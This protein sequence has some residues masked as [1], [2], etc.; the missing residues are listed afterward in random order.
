MENFQEAHTPNPN[1]ISTFASILILSP[2]LKCLNTFRVTILNSFK[3]LCPTP[4]LKGE[5][6]AQRNKH[7]LKA[8]VGSFFK[9]LFIL[10]TLYF[11]EEI[12]YFVL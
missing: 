8:D 1:K 4:R 10:K 7:L 2:K 6:E 3:S 9:I 5:N 12:F 11:D